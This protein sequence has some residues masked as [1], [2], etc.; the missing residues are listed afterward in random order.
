MRSKGHIEYYLRF[1]EAMFD[2]RENFSRVT[3]PFAA[4]QRQ[5]LIIVQALKQET[6]KNR[7]TCMPN[8]RRQR[9]L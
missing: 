6:N 7:T 8:P 2:L 3:H 5:F 4:I 1:H 9:S